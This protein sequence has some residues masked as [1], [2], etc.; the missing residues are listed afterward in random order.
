MK[1]IYLAGPDVFFNNVEELATNLKAICAEFGLQGVFP[2]D[3]DLD[4]DDYP[5][6]LEKGTAIYEANIQLIRSC[7]GVLANMTPFR[8]PSMDIGTGYEMGV[9]KG[10]E[11]PV[12]G[13]THDPREYK[14]RFCPD[15][16]LI[17]RFDMVDNL[18]VHC[19]A[20]AIF[21]TAREA[22]EGLASLL[23]GAGGS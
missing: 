7:D 22:V 21:P 16:R 2:L 19:G 10:L 6:P 5:T 3:A 1:R 20:E 18:M 9:A 13:Y 12:V 15:G 11:I 14:D 23:G 8:G 17:E 4:L